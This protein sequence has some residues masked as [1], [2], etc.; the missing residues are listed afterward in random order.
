[1]RSTSKQA[2][3]GAE[4]HLVV[5]RVLLRVFVEDNVGRAERVSEPVGD[6]V[7][8]VDVDGVTE[9]VGDGDDDGAVQ[10]PIVMFEESCMCLPSTASSH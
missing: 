7:K 4:T 3:H 2:R 8:V 6:A 9:T 1:M 10:F 5:D